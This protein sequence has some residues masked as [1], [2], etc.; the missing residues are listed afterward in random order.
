[1]EPLSGLV[2]SDLLH[3]SV[4]TN[5]LI[6]EELIRAP[7]PTRPPLVSSPNKLI[8]EGAA[9]AGNLIKYGAP[10]LKSVL[11]GQIYDG[12]LSGEIVTVLEHHPGPGSPAVLYLS[13]E[14]RHGS[15]FPRTPPSGIR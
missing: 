6:P 15:Q 13:A 9:F 11:T 14:H 3:V 10:A 8:K 5:T 4:S 12:M 7:S 2:S 1:M